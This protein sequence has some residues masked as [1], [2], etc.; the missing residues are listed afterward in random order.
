MRALLVDDHEIVRRGLAALVAGEF[1]DAECG[2]A[3]GVAEAREKLFAGGWDLVLLDISLPGG[4]GLS[5]LKDAK[6]LSPRPAILV[7]SSHPEEEFALRS[8]KLGADGYLT[9]ASVADEMKL[10]LRKV[11]SGGKYVSASMAEAM[12][13]AMGS[14]GYGDPHERLSEREL[15]VLRRVASGQTIK[16]IAAELSLSEKTIGTYRS[17]LSKKLGLSTNVEIAR[18]AL[19]HG[20]AD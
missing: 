3:S 2:E 6:S 15:E 8:F 7:L 1:P 14:G 10:A 13:S 20:L 16:A 17:R 18:Y 19:K 12:A 11:L 4:S 5:L 9:K